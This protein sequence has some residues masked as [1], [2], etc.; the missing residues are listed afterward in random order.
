MNSHWNL[1]LAIGY[2]KITGNPSTENLALPFEVALIA[3]QTLQ[4]KS[5]ELTTMGQNLDENFDQMDRPYE[6]TKHVENL[7]K[8]RQDLW[9]GCVALSEAY[10][11]AEKM[12]ASFA[13][14]EQLG[15]L[16]NK[17]YDELDQ[18]DDILL[19]N[20]DLLACIADTEFLS[21]CRGVLAG[22]YAEILPWWLD[23]R[24]ERAAAQ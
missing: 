12:G 24:I 4:T 7:L 5:K 20:L 18:A 1:T 13:Q 2:G 15:V 8:L 11:S 19:K 17:A 14:A 22:D 16:L 3:T 23:G 9:A 6:F 21:Q 10:V